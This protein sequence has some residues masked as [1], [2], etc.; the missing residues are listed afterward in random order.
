MHGGENI[1]V[2]Y[3]DGK[4]YLYA[5]KDVYTLGKYDITNIVPSSEIT[6][7]T[8]VKEFNISLYTNF[9]RMKEGWGIE[10]RDMTSSGILRRDTLT[11]YNSD[12]SNMVNSL[13]ITPANSILYSN[14]SDAL[15]KNGA[16]KQGMTLIDNNIFQT[17]GGNWNPN[18]DKVT[19]VYHLQ[20]VQ[21]IGPSG[22]VINDFTFMPQDIYDYLT[23]LNKKPA[24]IEHESAF[25]YNNKLFCLVVYKKMETSDADKSGILLVEYGATDK[26]YTFENIGKPFIAPT[27]K[28]NP[29]KLNIDNYLYNE[30]TGEKLTDIKQLTKY[31]VDSYQNKIVFYTS[32]VRMNDFNND[33]LP[34][35]IKVTIENMNNYTLFLN[36]EDVNGI[37][38]KF[39]INYQ[40]I[41]NCTI[42]PINQHARYDGVDLLQIND[43]F[44]GYL[45]NTKNIPSG[46]SASGWLKS[47]ISLTVKRIEYS[48]YNTADVYVNTAYQDTWMGWKKIAATSI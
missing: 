4:R 11:F 41:D 5:K 24:M 29:Y 8:P 26:D 12:F 32:N 16:K 43:S 27:A 38:R 1:H 15:M 3:E 31:M 22:D 7:L 36:Y 48:P 20:G 2:E 46:V 21:Q 30:F 23:K 47:K 9:F 28:Y 14:Q 17:V 33:P 39:I 35:G 10:A 18:R 42:K 40:T 45:T 19:N 44:E 37:K 13:N 25:N 34:N 6:E